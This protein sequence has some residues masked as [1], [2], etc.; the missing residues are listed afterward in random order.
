MSFYQ[1]Y[2]SLPPFAH[3]SAVSHSHRTIAS[4]NYMGVT[5]SLMIST[6]RF[7]FPS[8]LCSTMQLCRAGQPCEGIAGQ[9]TAVRTS[10]AEQSK[11]K[12]MS[13]QAGLH[14]TI[15]QQ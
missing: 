12:V 11:S 9:G 7:I 5:R 15:T 10:R 13:Y 3:L 8:Q 1:S 2:T 6:S 4:S 14:S